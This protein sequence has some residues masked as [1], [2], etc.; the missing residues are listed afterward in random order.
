MKI[1]LDKLEAD[2]ME[3]Y[4]ESVKINFGVDIVQDATELRQIL[5]E[6]LTPLSQESK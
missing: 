5:E 1:D 4:Y 2:I 3:W 6:N